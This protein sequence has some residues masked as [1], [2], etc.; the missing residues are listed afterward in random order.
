MMSSQTR[1]PA[2]KSAKKTMTNEA[3]KAAKK[4]FTQTHAVP[5]AAIPE[6]EGEQVEIRIPADARWVRLVRLGAAGVASVLNFSVEEIEDIK[7]AVSEAC[8]N[9]ILHAQPI[10]T[11]R[12]EP[13]PTILITLIPARDYLEIRVE[14]QGRLGR[15]ITSPSPK[16]KIS[17]SSSDSLP[18]GGLGLLIMQTVMDEV[19]YH[20]G[21]DTNTKLCM[22]KYRRPAEGQAKR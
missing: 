12:S 15:E 10:H 20:T 3:T 2:R 9:A 21:D 22:V 8:N 5:I 19:R 1:K 7:L 11:S 16:Q 17:S 6:N 14:D 13:R 18:V 4:T